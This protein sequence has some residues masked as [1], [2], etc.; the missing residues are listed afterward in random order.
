MSVSTMEDMKVELLRLQAENIRQQRAN[1]DRENREKSASQGWKLHCVNSTNVHSTNV[2]SANGHEHQDA[3]I[4]HG[5][6]VF[7]L[8]NHVSTFNWTK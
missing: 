3:R 7:N 2:P 4:G 1:Q 8:R 6:H 5:R